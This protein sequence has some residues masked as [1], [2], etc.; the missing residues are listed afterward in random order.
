MVQFRLFHFCAAA[1]CSAAFAA[2]FV[3]P[4]HAGVVCD[5]LNS[6]KLKDGTITSAQ[7][8]AAGQFAPPPG[9][10]PEGKDLYSKLPA[11]CRAQAT[12]KPTSDSDIHIEVWLPASGWN[13]KFVETGNGA[14]V[15]S[16]SFNTMAQGLSAGYAVTGSDTGHSGNSADF[17]LGHPEKLIDFGYRAVHEDAL[18]ARAIVDAYYG[19]APKEAYFEGCSTGGRQGLGEA[20]RY[21][22]DFNGIVVGDPG[23]NGTHQTASELWMNV[24]AHKDPGAPIPA[25]KLAML[26]AAV[27]NACDA[28]DGVKDGV[29]ENPQACRFDPATLACKNG[30][31]PDCLTAPQVEL[32]R[33][34]YSGAISPT[35]QHIF[36][37]LMPGTETGWNGL[38]GPKP[39]GYALDVYRDLVFQNPNWDYMTLDLDRDVPHADQT[40]GPAFNNNDPNLKPFFARGGKLIGYHGAADSGLTPYNSIEYYDSVAKLMG[41]R[42]AIANDYRLFLVPGMGHCGG[43]DGTSTFD[44]LTAIDLWV[45]AG[46]APDS[47]PA[48]RTRNGAVDRTRPLCPYPQQAVYKGSGSTDDAANFTCAAK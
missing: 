5:K 10:P 11:F 13:G 18:A 42:Q 23:I 27:L 31:A 3:A 6:V 9:G 17:V 43:G 1:S 35:G 2:I 29:I 44:M 26:H 45:T 37:G 16:P 40:L 8:V 4:A 33:T 34:M 20:Q 30:D 7:V 19:A 36:P 15:G 38:A 32:A 48:A 47:I 46:K 41:G 39:M 24:V 28:I 22:A 12:L 25:S 14:F 21:P